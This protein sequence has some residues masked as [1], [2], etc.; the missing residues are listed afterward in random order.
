MTK[1]TQIVVNRLNFNEVL[2]KLLVHNPTN[3]AFPNVVTVRAITLISLISGLHLEEVVKLKWSAILSI[4]SKSQAQINEYITINR[5][6]EFPINQKLR[7]QLSDFYTSLKHPNPESKI[8]DGLEDYN[9]IESLLPRMNIGFGLLEWREYNQD[10]LYRYNNK[11]LTQILFGRRVF[12]VCGY[13]NETSKFLKTFFSKKTNR[14]LFYFLGYESR[15]DINYSLANISLVEGQKHRYEHGE[16]HSFLDDNKHFYVQIKNSKQYYPFQHF[17]VFYDFLNK[18]SLHKNSIVTQGMIL[19]LL[20]SLTNGIRLSLLLKFKWSDIFIDNKKDSIL[21]LKEEII[22]KKNKL[23]INS[24]ILKKIFIYY[25][26]A[27][28]TSGISV[29]AGNKISYTNEPN[30]DYSI[31]MTSRGNPLTQPSLHREMTRALHELGFIHADKFSTKSTLIMY[32]RR[33]IEL[34]GDHKPTIKLLKEHFNFRSTQALFDF[35]YINEYKGN[36][37]TSIRGFN[38]VWEHILYDV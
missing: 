3:S 11:H 1:S 32:G 4:N 7:N 6:Y 9:G 15:N 35:L 19:L 18:S 5:H 25:K 16:S 29:L 28:V 31:I 26:K 12:E 20:I 2:S 34:K 33:I 38:S 23:I 10:E 8:I 13:T 36:K 21:T 17:Q 22:L 27:M 24:D 14:G 30:L 37:G